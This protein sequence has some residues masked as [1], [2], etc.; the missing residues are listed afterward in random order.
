MSPCIGFFY[1]VVNFFVESIKCDDGNIRFRSF[2]F[3]FYVLNAICGVFNLCSLNYAVSGWVFHFVYKEH[4]I[5]IMGSKGI[6]QSL[7]GCG[8]VRGEYEVVTGVYD[9]VLVNRESLSA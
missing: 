1:V 6:H 7:K 2:W 9:E 8:G 4:C 3:L 5:G